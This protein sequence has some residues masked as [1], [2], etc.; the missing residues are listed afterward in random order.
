MHPFSTNSLLCFVFPGARVRVLEGHNC[1]RTAEQRPK[2]RQARNCMSAHGDMQARFLVTSCREAVIIS[3]SSTRKCGLKGKGK[4]SL[5]YMSRAPSE[6]SRN[7]RVSWWTW[8]S[9]TASSGPTNHD[10]EPIFEMFDLLGPKS[11]SRTRP[12]FYGISTLAARFVGNAS[13]SGRTASCS[14][15][16]PAN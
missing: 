11:A 6:E 3:E 9:D 10:A 14:P 5:L 8:R 15:T 2:R 4:G 16:A 7:K 13:N 12:E 1:L